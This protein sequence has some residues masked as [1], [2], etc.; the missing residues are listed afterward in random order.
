MASSSPPVAIK[1]FFFYVIAPAAARRPPVRILPEAATARQAMVE[2]SASAVSQSVTVDAQH[3]LLVH[4]EYLQSSSMQGRKD[5]KW[6]LDWRLPFTSLFSGMFALTRIRTG[7]NNASGESIT[8]SSMRDPLSEVASLTLPEG[9]AMVLQSRVLVAVLTPID[10]PLR[11]TRH[12][13]L[14][15][16]QA[17]LTL[18]LRYVVFHG[19]ALL[20]VKG[21]RGIRMEHA[22]TGR[23]I[24]Q[25][26]TLGF[27]AHAD[28]AVARGETFAAYAWS[29]QALF[30]DRFAGENAFYIYE[31]IPRAGKR[32]G[33][34][35]RGLEGLTDALL[36]VFGIA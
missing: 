14:F 23:R 24:D 9:A 18:Q 13:R 35:G 26:A 28:Y 21:T 29:E 1:A 2:T 32:G 11:I 8:I 36:K 16:L 17:W 6:L 10:Q 30:S 31:E 12:W 25:A 15:S 5:T 34:T 7:P 27:S 20:V 4:P 19:P 3:E 22:G 33:V